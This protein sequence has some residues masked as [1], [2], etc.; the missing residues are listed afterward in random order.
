MARNNLL[1]RFPISLLIFRPAIIFLKLKLRFIFELTILLFFVPSI[2][3]IHS[4][5]HYL[6]DLLLILILG[7]NASA[8]VLAQQASH[9]LT[10]GVL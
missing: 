2:H 5:I 9:R 10:D 4:R 7:V 6:V 8:V 1:L 3:T